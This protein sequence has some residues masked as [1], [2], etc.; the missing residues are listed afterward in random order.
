MLFVLLMSAIEQTFSAHTR[1]KLQTSHRG[2]SPVGHVMSDVHGIVVV[3]VSAARHCSV[4]DHSAPRS[5]WKER[6]A[7]RSINQLSTGQ[8]S[9]GLPF[10]RTRSTASMRN[11]LPTGR[12]GLQRIAS[13]LLHAVG[14]ID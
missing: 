7:D 14:Y 12:F 1:R 13:P 10:R 6:S 3:L 2:W 11:L 5:G 8:W 9:R 4:A